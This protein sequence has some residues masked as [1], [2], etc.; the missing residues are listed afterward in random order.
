MKKFKYIFLIVV[1]VLF[2]S[3]CVKD[4]TTIGI[5]K[6]KSMTYE[7]E[8]LFSNELGDDMT[9][10]I[11]TEEYEQA[12]YKVLSVSG[13]KY[14]GVKISKKFSNID[15]FSNNKG[16]EI[17]IN[18]FLEKDFDKSVLFKKEDNFIKETYTA[19]FKYSIKSSDYSEYDEVEESN[20]IEVN[21][22]EETEDDNENDY[23]N[24][25]GEMEFTFKVNLPYKANS[26]TAS[27]VKKN[28]K[29]LTWNLGLDKES[30][31]EFEFSIYNRKNIIILASS[32]IA[33][34][35]ILIVV[36]TIIKKKRAS[37]ETL[38]HKDYDPSIE[39]MINTE[40]FKNTNPIPPALTN[41]DSFNTK[42]EVSDMDSLNI[43]NNDGINNNF[44]NNNQNIQ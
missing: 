43:Q 25:M 28:G 41:L 13:E 44:P 14:N 29:E 31:I 36:L 5:K 11:N 17:V 21:D 39:N 12:G 32:I 19:K 22:E 37:R 30:Y 4:K 23:S 38:I 6:D 33:F 40:T 15:D 9:T 3:G 7:N 20:Y 18:D 1:C 16:E 24:I 27:K 8:I 42:A 26:N 35:I 10:K 2:L 34:I